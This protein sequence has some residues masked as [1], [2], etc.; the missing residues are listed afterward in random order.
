[1]HFAVLRF[2]FNDWWL[3]AQDQDNFS[4]R[5]HRWHTMQRHDAMLHRQ[6]NLVF[7]VKRAVFLAWHNL[8][9]VKPVRVRASFFQW[10]DFIANRRE[11][12]T[13]QMQ[14]SGAIA[15]IQERSKIKLMRLVFAVFYDAYA[16]L[17]RDVEWESMQVFFRVLCAFIRKVNARLPFYVKLG[18]YVQGFVD[19][20]QSVANYRG[21]CAWQP[22][23]SVVV[24]YAN[25]PSELRR[26]VSQ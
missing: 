17:A 8:K 5:R 3:Q 10:R 15:A 1:M 25:M 19:A 13:V 2:V 22:N 18:K 23:D 4:Q 20:V 14:R 6:P 11:E 24:A 9:N 21:F 12:Q 26:E 7:A 16:A